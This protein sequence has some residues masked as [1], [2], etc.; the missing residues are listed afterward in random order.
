AA[1]FGSDAAFPGLY[2]REC[3]DGRAN[4]HDLWDCP[5]DKVTYPT[6]VVCRDADRATWQVEG[7]ANLV[8]EYWSVRDYLQDAYANAWVQVARRVKGLPNVIGYDLMNEPVGYHIMLAV[9][10]LVQLGGVTDAMILNLV[11]GLVSDP[12]VA[13]TIALLV[14]ALGLIPVLPEV[15]PEPE[16]PVPPVPPVD[17]GPGADADAIDRYR[18]ETAL[19]TI[20]LEAYQAE[21]AAYDADIATWPARKEAAEAARLD[22]LKSWGLA[23]EGPASADP[24]EAGEP[25]VH[26]LDL[27]SLIDLN[28]SFDWT[29]LRPFY[30]RVGNAI[31][32]ED[33]EAL[34]FI[35]G[36]MGL[37][38]VGYDLGMPT[39]EGLEGRVV[40]AP[41]HYEDIYPFL[42]FN[43]SPRF[44]KVEEVAHR[45]YTQGMR[46]AALLATQSLGNA[47]VVFGE[48]GAYY[49]F[50]GIEQSIADDY[51][52]TK[53]IH[54]N[55]FEGF[56]ALFAS[57]MLWC[58]S[59]DNDMRFGDLWN[60]EDFSIQSFPVTDADGNVTRPWRAQEVWARPHARALAGKPV[61]THFYSPY[62][63]FDPDK[64]MPNPVGEF[65]VVYESKESDR[66]TEIQIPYDI[67]YPDG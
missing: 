2:A 22:V 24:A 58:Y 21:K 54:D 29:Y 6:H 62:H 18:V 9:Q 39:P 59:P 23:W 8:E 60:K 12:L 49:N 44:F 42:G 32:T 56:E 4:P 25:V 55:F 30:E 3:R 53:H 35:E 52:I 43:V 37:G 48:F 46:N 27:F 45:D 50:N 17:P 15:P 20:A 13:E 34:I 65:E 38:S 61:S 19:Y 36:S 5:A 31:L 51:A 16:A 66:P 41:H 57:R 33:P 40:F 64:G 10:A 63:Y 7:C 26:N 1:F 11:K 14:P 28:T 67:Q 47:P